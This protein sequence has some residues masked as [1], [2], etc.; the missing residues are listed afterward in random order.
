MR[1]TSINLLERPETGQILALS[2]LLMAA[3]LPLTPFLKGQVVGFLLLLFGVRIAALKW[4]AA[5]PAPWLRLLLTLAGI[6]NCLHAYQS[7]TGQYGGTALLAT[8]LVLKLLE[9]NSKRDLRLVAILIG[10]LTV[11][12]FLFDQSLPLVLYL[13]AV[14][15]GALTLLVDLNGQPQAPRLRSALRV[16]TRLALQ[17]L[18]LTLVLFVLFPRLSSPIWTLG[19]DSDQ[20][21][22]GMSDSMEPGQIIELVLNTELAFRVRFDAPPPKADQLYWRG[23]VLWETDGRRWTPGRFPTQSTASARLQTSSDPID[24]EILLEPTKQKWLFALDMPINKPDKSILTPDFRL[25]ARQPITSAK[26]YQVTSALSYRTEETDPRL[27]ELALRLPDNIT[28]RMRTLVSNW[29]IQTAGDWELVQRGLAFFNREEFRYT[30]LPPRLGAN[31]ADE[32][33][34]ETRSGYCEHYAGSFALLMRIGGVPSRVVLGYLGGEVNRIGGYHMVLQ[35]NAHAWVEV[36]IDGRGWV[37]VD[38][39]AAVDPA[40]VDHRSASRVL[41]TGNSVRFDLDPAGPIAGLVKQMRLLADTIDATWQSWVL[42]FSAADQLALLDRLGLGPFGEYGLAA[43]MVL[44]VSLTLALILLTLMRER[45][46]LDPLETQYA[47]FCQRL[48][49]AGLPRLHNEGPSAFGRRVCVARPDLALAVGQFLAIY[50]PARFGPY[51]SH[52]SAAQLARQLRRFRPRRRPSVP[53]HR[54]GAATPAKRS[55]SKSSG[56]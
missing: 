30:L 55:R 51:Q 35:S 26:R 48:A 28:P 22:T 47:R 56:R 14:V 3:L 33:L 44:T 50:V 46:S 23:L 18:P 21:L 25:L 7:L 54:L 27:R 16:T 42:D 11:V 8:M 29:Q 17:A 36:L 10:F 12:Q 34:F 31:P 40:R 41:G 5:L 4:S 9:L 1:K 24:Y 39:T 19:I 53:S 15:L 49:Q 13:G 2:L 45:T 43:L 20:G 6:A 52:A 37:R 32:F 38:P